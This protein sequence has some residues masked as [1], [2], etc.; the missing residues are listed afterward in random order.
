VIK[1]L[2]QKFLTKYTALLSAGMELPNKKLL[3]GINSQGLVVGLA[4][5]ESVRSVNKTYQS[6]TMSRFAV[7]A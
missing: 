5:L 3:R 4:K 7:S 6:T 1:V 2:K